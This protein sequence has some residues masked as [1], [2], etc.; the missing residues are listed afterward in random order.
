MSSRVN[1]RDVAVMGWPSRIVLG[2][3]FL[4][5]AVPLAGEDALPANAL[6]RGADATDPGEKIDKAEPSPFCTG[7]SNGNSVAGQE[8]GRT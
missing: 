7:A 5:V 4:R 2:V 1:L 8:Q 3:G 6:E